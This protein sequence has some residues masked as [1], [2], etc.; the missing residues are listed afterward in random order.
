MNVSRNVRVVVRKERNKVSAYVFY[1][2]GGLVERKTSVP[3][4]EF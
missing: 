2:P 4:F 3:A 1:R